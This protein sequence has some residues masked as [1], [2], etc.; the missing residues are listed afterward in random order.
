MAEAEKM[1]DKSLWR[2]EGWNQGYED[3]KNLSLEEFKR[4]DKG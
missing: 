4:A 1:E 3:C 2:V